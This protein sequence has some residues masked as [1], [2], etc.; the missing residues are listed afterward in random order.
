MDKLPK[1]RLFTDQ[2]RYTEEALK[3]SGEFS[4]ALGPVLDKWYAKGYS[5]RDMAN[6]LDGTC[7]E[8]T[9]MRI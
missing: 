4:Q 9:L 2:D 6:V 7:V 5:M 1:K 8:E 3:L